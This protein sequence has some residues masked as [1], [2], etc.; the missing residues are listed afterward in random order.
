MN[1]EDVNIFAPNATVKT[2][3][4]P[5]LYEPGTSWLYSTSIDW[6]GKMVE[7]A[8]GQRLDEF[9]QKN[10]FDPLGCK[11]LTFFPTD[12]IKQKKMAVCFRDADGTPKPFPGGFGMGRPQEVAG[13]ST[14][15]LLGGA[16]LFGCQKDYLTILRAILKSDPSS[17]HKSDKPLLSP[18]SFKEL[19][20]GCI[21]TEAGRQGMCDQVSRPA[22][23]DPPVSTKNVDH[24]VGFL[25]NLEDMTGR[26]K[27]GSGCWSGA[28]KSQFWID[29]T[30][31]IAVSHRFTLRRSGILAEP[32]GYLRYSAF[33]PSS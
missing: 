24:S 18:Q 14:E 26:R 12:E 16:G 15:L 27:K 21:S 2:I 8:S 7:R 31:G 11:T 23:F 25:I 32:V 33:V 10:I 19:F 13:V 29:P 4:K 20:T 17:P 30:T 22:Y 5:L 28:A 6:V 3:C 1:P 9:F